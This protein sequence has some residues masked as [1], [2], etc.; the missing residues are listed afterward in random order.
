METEAKSPA[1]ARVRAVVELI[2]FSICFLEPVGIHHFLCILG[3]CALGDFHFFCKVRAVGHPIRDQLH[4]HFQGLRLFVRNADFAVGVVCNQM[5]FVRRDLFLSVSTRLSETG[6]E[7]RA[8][9]VVGI[10]LSIA[11]G[12][13]SEN[14]ILALARS[15][16]FA[17]TT[18]VMHNHDSNLS[19]P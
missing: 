11:E 12:N 4:E 13:D 14:A 8:A 2:P 17:A 16:H 3:N 5:P 6:D 19:S 10:L 9:F 7:T 1:L 18:G 15:A